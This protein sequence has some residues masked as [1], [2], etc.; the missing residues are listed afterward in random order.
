MT[1]LNFFES[2][3]SSVKKLLSSHQEVYAMSL[4]VGGD[5]EAVGQLEYYL[6]LQSGLQ[7]EHVIIDVGCGSGRLELQLKNYLEGRYIGIDVVPALYK[8]A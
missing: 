4:A 7:R 1:L 2:Y 3:N 6:L 5:F 8:Y